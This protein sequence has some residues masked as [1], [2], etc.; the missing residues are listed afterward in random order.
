MIFGI[1]DLSIIPMRSKPS[2]KEEM[3]NQVL[4]GEHFHIIEKEK[5]WVKIESFSIS[6]P[7]IVIEIN[8]KISLLEILE[9]LLIDHCGIHSS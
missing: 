2:D 7:I 9:N 1:C 6:K 3:I 5:D 8:V 4:F